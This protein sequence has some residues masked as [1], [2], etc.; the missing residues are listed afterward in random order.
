MLQVTGV[1]QP[2]PRD[3]KRRDYCFVH[4]ADHSVV[5]RLI[6]DG[7]KGV[8]PQLDG[9]ALDVSPLECCLPA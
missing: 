1:V 7:E 5:E 2:P 3:G 6:A 9:N 8:K 4:F